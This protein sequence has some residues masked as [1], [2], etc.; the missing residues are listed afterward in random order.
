M[1]Q[2]TRL[3]RNEKL[4]GGLDISNSKGLEIGALNAPLLKRTEANIRFVDHAD[5]ETLKTKYAGDSNVNPDDIVP[6]DA[7]W[8]GG[9]TL[10]ECFPHETFDYVIASHVIEH[11]PDFIGCLSEVADILTPE[12]R[13]ILA[14]P[15]RRYT[16]DFLRQ[17]TRLSDVIDH[18][19]R[20]VKRPTPGQIF[21][22]L[23][24]RG[25]STVKACSWTPLKRP[26]KIRS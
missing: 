16:F 19:L 26:T 14:I 6:V 9:R 21:D 22:A 12:G 20:P 7:I 23:S 4:L 8:G 24:C 17:E 3:S 10:A 1:D 11:V 13:L 15:D 5:Q 2:I 25:A 18:H